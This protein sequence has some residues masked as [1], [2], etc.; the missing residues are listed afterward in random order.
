M[1]DEEVGRRG[2][3]TERM[4]TEMVELEEVGRRGWRTEEDEVGRR[5]WRTA[6][7][8]DGDDGG[9]GGG[10][11]GWTERMEDGRRRTER[12]EDIAV[13]ISIM[14]CRYCIDIISITI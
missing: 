14:Q 3:R 6:M 2:W 12:M 13:L 7:M 9:G 5:G 1:E 8:E 4:W 11:G 10:R